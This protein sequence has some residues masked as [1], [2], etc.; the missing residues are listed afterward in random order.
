MNGKQKVKKMKKIQKA[1]MVDAMTGRN[2]PIIMNSFHGGLGRG[3]GI[4]VTSHSAPGSL[5]GGLGG[6]IGRAPGS[7]HG[8]GRV[9]IALMT[10]F[11]TKSF[12]LS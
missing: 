3:T 1:R 8:A 7:I 11:N 5:H 6:G 2:N 9:N 12:Y 10:S 4:P